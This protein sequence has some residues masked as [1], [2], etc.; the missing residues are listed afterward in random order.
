MRI[1]RFD[2][3]ADQGL[4]RACH[5]LMEAGRPFDDPAMP[6]RSVALFSSWW[7]NDGEPRQTWLASDETGEPVGCYLLILPDR[8]NPTMAMCAL[9][10]A[11]A[12]RRSGLGTELL[13]HCAGQA[14]LAGRSRLTGEVTENSP[15]AAF[16]AAVGATSGIAEVYRVLT[17][18]PGFRQRLSDLRRSAEQRASGYTLV[19][20]LGASPDEHLD[21][22]ARL[23]GAMADAPRDPGVEPEV[24]DGGRI[25]DQ[26]RAGLAN[27]LTYY[28]V[29]ARREDTGAIAALTQLATDPGS[30]GWAFQSLTAVLREHRGHRLGLLAK[31]A[32][33]DLLLDREPG[34]SRILTSNAGGNE[35]M[36][37]IN[38]MLGFEAC[39][40]HRS[41]E[42]DLTGRLPG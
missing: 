10:V 4:L 20:W 11:P 33:L 34:V 12:S 21:D 25:R 14:R 26:E 19:S 6:P 38:E 30:P 1:E 23:S 16:A 8:A 39:S 2:P 28:S 42:L 3:R 27:G 24:W 7:A 13:A 32:M 5:E 22:V 17:I 15:G 36:I 18:D 41:W 35:H 29:A 9:T 40:V 37:A 31:V